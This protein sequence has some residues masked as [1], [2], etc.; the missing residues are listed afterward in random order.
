MGRLENGIAHARMTAATTIVHRVQ[1]INPVRNRSSAPPC[2]PMPPTTQCCKKDRQQTVDKKN[3]RHPRHQTTLN[4]GGWGVGGRLVGGTSIP[5]GGVRQ[6]CLTYCDPSSGGYCFMLR[7]YATAT[8][9][10]LIEALVVI[11]FIAATSAILP[12]Q[13]LTTHTV[14]VVSYMVARTCHLKQL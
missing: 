7:P 14:S 2:P 4:L 13:L 1:A 9:S 12:Q 6:T 3:T 5:H 8:Y 11:T 10:H